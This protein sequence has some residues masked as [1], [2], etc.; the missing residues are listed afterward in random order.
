[1]SV[2]IKGM[3]MPKKGTYIDIVILDDGTVVCYDDD[4]KIGE[5]VE[6][7]DHGDLIDRDEL[8]K[9]LIDEGETVGIDGFSI[10]GVTADDVCYAIENAPVVIPTEKSE[11]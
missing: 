11:E 9:S 10:D 7:P 8:R 4:K 3:K 1:M 2:L 6:L 5:A